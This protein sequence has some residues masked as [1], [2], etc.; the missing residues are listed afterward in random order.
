MRPSRR[1]AVIVAVVVLV[2][3]LAFLGWW[4]LSRDDAP[5]EAEP[6]PTPTV[7]ATPTATPRPTLTPEP[8]E[9]AEPSQTTQPSA[10]PTTP[11]DPA[12]P[13]PTAIDVV[14]TY[15]FWNDA[16][17][18][19]EAAGYANTVE[20]AGTCTMTATQGGTSATVSIAASPDAS[21]MACGG[22]SLGRDQLGSGTWQVVI[23]YA[24]SA[25]AGAAAPV[26]VE[27]P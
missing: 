26:T 25:F 15:A 8:G 27:I 7:S 13:A 21:T 11:D 6:S 10:A 9:P 4:L 2:A 3:V 14:A 5:S 24:S 16:T 12:V 17:S 22:L 20:S 19:L 18:A 1:T 23:S